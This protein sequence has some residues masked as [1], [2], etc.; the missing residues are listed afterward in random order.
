MTALEFQMDLA[1]EIKKITENMTFKNKAGSEV[2]LEVFIQNLPVKRAEVKSDSDDEDDEDEDEDK[3]P[4][5]E[6][7]IMSS[8][9]T[10]PFP[11]CIIRIEDGFQEDAASPV[12]VNTVLII[13]LYNDDCKAQGHQDILNII[14]KITER[15]Y[16]NPVLNQRYV[17]RDRDGKQQIQWDLEESEMYS[18]FFGGALMT[19]CLPSISPEKNV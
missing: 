2:P 10:E 7:Q 14:Q 5:P 18:Y 3:L 9:E 11:Y 17:M 6:E 8:E 12:Y 19:W 13:G 16:K 1:D 4:I 15:F